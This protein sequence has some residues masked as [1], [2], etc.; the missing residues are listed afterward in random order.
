MNRYSQTMTIKNIIKYILWRMGYRATMP[1][2]F[3]NRV[4]IRDN[5]EDLVDIKQNHKLF[6]APSLAEKEHVFL[7]QGVY[8][9]LQKAMENLPE[10][11]TFKIYSAYRSMDDQKALWNNTFNKVKAEFPYLMPADLENKVRAICADP[12]HGFGGHQTGG[13]VDITLCDLDGNDIDMG[14]GHLDTKGNTA[15]FTQGLTEEQQQNRRLLYHLMRNAGFQ[16]YPNEWWHYCYGD[17]M[18]AAYQCKKYA[19]YGLVEKD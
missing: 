9:K 17:R 11:L 3:V 6:F 1:A 10:G 12:R 7:R 4:P 18:W 8:Q 15:T 14:G 13:A 2:I 5:G 19:I 16:N